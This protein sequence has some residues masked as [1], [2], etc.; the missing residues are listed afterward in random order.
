LGKDLKN[1]HGIPAAHWQLDAAKQGRLEAVIV[2]L[3][4]GI[5]THPDG[6]FYW[7][8]KRTT[9]WMADTVEQVIKCPEFQYQVGDR[10]YLQEEWDSQPGHDG[11]GNY[12][13]TRSENPE[14]Q[15][16]Y[17][18][19]DG[20]WQPAHTMPPD[21]AQYY[22]QVTGV[23]GVQA[24]DVAILSMGFSSGHSSPRLILE[25]W[26]QDWN[27]AH[28]EQTWDGDRWVIVLDVEAIS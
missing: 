9:A 27:A 16:L 20:F 14:K 5:E 25:E 4:P 2:P 23:R 1:T 15:D 8:N 12:F 24:K 10:L 19:P 22:Y 7:P 6:S 18:V 17:W 28:P 3:V 26:A 13:Y 11:E 21:A